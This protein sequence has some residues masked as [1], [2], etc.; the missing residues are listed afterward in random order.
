MKYLTFIFLLLSICTFAQNE[1]TVI[2]I[3]GV[4]VDVLDADGFLDDLGAFETDVVG[5]IERNQKLIAEM[6]FII[7]EQQQIIEKLKEEVENLKKKVTTLESMIGVVEPLSAFDEMIEFMRG[8]SL[9]K[10]NSEYT[11]KEI[12]AIV[13]DIPEMPNWMRS[14]AG[15]KKTKVQYLIDN[16]K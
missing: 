11:E 5:L 3:N 4:E 1:V 6:K 9:S 2:D 16:Y 8:N 12:V 14:T 13:Q 10:F 15:A 7:K